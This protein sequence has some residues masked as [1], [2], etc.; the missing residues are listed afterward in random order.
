LGIFGR[1]AKVSSK[2]QHLQSSLRPEKTVGTRSWRWDLDFLHPPFSS[3]CFELIFGLSLA[4]F[5]CRF[6]QHLVLPLHLL[7][8]ILGDVSVLGRTLPLIVLKSNPRAQ[9]DPLG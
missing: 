7:G 2:E 6:M 9:F 5:G 1:H 4:Y 3:V 8:K